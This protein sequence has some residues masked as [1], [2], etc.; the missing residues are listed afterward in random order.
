V[1]LNAE[2]K[3][4][5]ILVNRKYW[6]KGGGFLFEQKRNRQIKGKETAIGKGDIRD[7]RRE[8]KRGK[9]GVDS[10]TKGRG[11]KNSSREGDLHQWV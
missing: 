8:K 10:G 5:G 6:G 1:L 9:C 11:P 2:G 7:C 3:G 4:R